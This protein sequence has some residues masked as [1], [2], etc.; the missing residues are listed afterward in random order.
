MS[1]SLFAIIAYDGPGDDGARASHHDGHVAHFKA[2]KD[3]I[4]VSGPLSGP[5]SGSLVIYKAETLEEA[6][7]FIESDPFFPAGVWERVE[8]TN[9]KASMGDWV[10]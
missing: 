3:K 7:T 6:R 8:V 5:L 2:H 1:A 9:F 4:A 10:A